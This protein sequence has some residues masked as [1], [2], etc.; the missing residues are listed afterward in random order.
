MLHALHF[1]P[2]LLTPCGSQPVSL[3]ITNRVVLLEA[4]DQAAFKQPPQR[5]KERPCAHPYTII[6]ERFDVLDQAVPVPGLVGQAD[7]DQ[8][9]RL[10]QRLGCRVFP[11]HYNMSPRDI[12]RRREWTVKLFVLLARSID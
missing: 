7:Q 11:I 10:A 2:Q 1:L 6:A 8:E 9:N 5:P 3:L 12:L 4:L